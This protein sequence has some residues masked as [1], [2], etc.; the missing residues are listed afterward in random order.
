M[1]ATEP[2]SSA[3]RWR[4]A[5]RHSYP[6]ALGYVPAA[7]AFGVLMSAAGLPDWLAAASSLIVY[8]G[9]AQYASVA[10]F[11]A[12]AGIFSMTL[13]TFIINLRH[14]FYAMPLLDELPKRRWERLYTL[15]ALTDESFSVLTT[16]P[17]ALRAQLMSRLVFCN[18][19]Y[20][21][22]GTLVGIGV[23]GDLNR[24]IPNLDF[25]LNCLFVV[26]AYE[27]YRSRRAWWPCVLAVAAFFAARA[28]TE[29]YL[30]LLAVAFSVLFIVCRSAWWKPGAAR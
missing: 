12:G 14:V 22:A 1:S 30:L 19:M 18:Q 29:Q 2:L 15:F 8:S 26:L 3:Q 9:A 10:W 24:L 6:I 7:I 4:Q 27:Q 20:W 16:L 23:G 17:A 5:L 13:N 28:L 21:L 11:A 25:A